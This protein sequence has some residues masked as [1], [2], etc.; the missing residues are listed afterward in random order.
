MGLIQNWLKSVRVLST[1]IN[2]LLI[3]PLW[4]AFNHSLQVLHWLALRT[5]NSVP[6]VAEILSGLS[7]EVTW[8]RV[9]QPLPT[10]NIPQIK[11]RAGPIPEQTFIDLCIWW[12]VCSALITPTEQ[13]QKSPSGIFAFHDPS[14]LFSQLRLHCGNKGLTPYVLPMLTTM[15]EVVR[16]TDEKC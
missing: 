10:S 4:C 6:T 3:R 1:G 15:P 11:P 5:G 9:S 14:V 7:G 2:R 8:V 13:H 12:I 16:S